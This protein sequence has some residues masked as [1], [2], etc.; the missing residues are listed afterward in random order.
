MDIQP[1]TEDHAESILEIYGPIVRDTAISFEDEV[2]SVDEMRRRIRDTLA[3]YPWLVGEEDG[4]LLGYGYAGPLRSRA[5]YRWSAEV[6]MYIRTEA[7]GRGVGTAIGM[8]MTEI[9]LRMGVV[10]L[11]GGTTLPNPAS[12]AIYRASGFERVGVWRNAGYKLGRWHDVGWFQRA[13]REGDADP[14]PFTPFS[15]LEG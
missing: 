3:T 8:E 5:A 14:P 4:E 6:S 11:F 13:I 1:A 9:L 15:E 7:R 12:E 10:N 2:P